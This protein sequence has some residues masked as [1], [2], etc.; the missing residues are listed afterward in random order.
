[1]ETSF[2]ESKIIENKKKEYFMK[3]KDNEYILVVY[4]ENNNIIFNIKQLNNISLYFYQNKYEL[5]E[6]LDVLKIDYKLIDNFEKIIELIN[7]AY[8]NN[9]LFIHHTNDQI[10]LKIV[11]CIELREYESTLILNKKEIDINEKFELIMKE[12][13]LLKEMNF[14]LINDKIKEIEKFL[15]DLKNYVEKKMEENKVLIHNLKKKI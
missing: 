10:N 8:S 4:I 9:K 3:N 1:M 12:L 2:T 6:I 14:K 7:K 13:E 5:N 15:F 11:F